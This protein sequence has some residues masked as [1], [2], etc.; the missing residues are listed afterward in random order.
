[1]HE[2]F[3][4]LPL[5]NPFLLENLGQDNDSLWQWCS[6]GLSQKSADKTES[7]GWVSVALE[8]SGRSQ[9][10]AGVHVFICIT[11][12]L[13]FNWHLIFCRYV[14]RCKY[15]LGEG[16]LCPYP[17]VLLWENSIAFVWKLYDGLTHLAWTEM[18]CAI[19]SA[20][21]PYVWTRLQAEVG[22]SQVIHRILGLG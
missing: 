10:C 2:I 11:C 19:Y 13:S 16:M 6:G 20:R 9:I 8:I 3:W 22:S 4:I 1:M 12:D 5:S 21:Y 18:C 7:D 14:S 17:V 15:R